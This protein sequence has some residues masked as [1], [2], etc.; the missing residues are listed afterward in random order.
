MKRLTIIFQ[1]AVLAVAG[2]ALA[3]EDSRLE[4]V[5]TGNQEQPQVLYLV[6]WQN[7]DSPTL[8][9][10]VIHHQTDIVFQ[11]LERSELLR[12]LKHLAPLTEPAPVDLIEPNTGAKT[13]GDNPNTNGAIKPPHPEANQRRKSDR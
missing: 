12:E 6:P 9:Y 1:L 13:Q 4:S 3:Q 10:D 7:P 11:H 2:S 8:Q 5:I